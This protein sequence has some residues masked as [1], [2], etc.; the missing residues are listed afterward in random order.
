MSLISSK[1]TVSLC[2]NF[3]LVGDVLEEV[4]PQ[5][6]VDHPVARVMTNCTDFD[7]NGVFKGLKGELV[8]EFNKHG[9][10]LSNKEHLKINC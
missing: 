8:H 2:S 4:L 1:N 10:S 5:P 3:Q 9:G 6:G 7:E